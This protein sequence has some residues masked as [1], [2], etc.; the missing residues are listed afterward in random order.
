ML[1]L[2]ELRLFL[3]G[4]E[5]E[6]TNLA[7][8]LGIDRLK[9]QLEELEARTAAPEFWND[10]ENSQ[11]VLQQTGQL[12]NKLTAYQN[13]VSLYEDTLTM[14][15]LA[16]EE[17]EVDEYPALKESADQIAEK[18]EE[19]KL[20]TLLNG[21]YDAKNAILTFHAGAGGTEAQD[22]AQMLYR[23]Y[24]RWVE[25]H[26][27]K[28]KLLDMLDG[29]EAGIK[30]ASILVEGMNAYGYLKSEAG[31][32]RLVRV[33]PFDASG[34]RHTSFASLEVMPEIDD[35]L[36]VTIDEKD[37]R[38]DTYRSSGAG[39]QHVNKTES[40]IRITHI[41]TGIVV[42]C[43]NERS[44]IQNREVAMR[45]LRSK[46]VEIKEREHLEKIEDIKGVQ[47]EIAWGSQIRSYVFMPYTLVKDHRTGFETGNIG[48]VMDG[49]IDGFINAYLKAASLG[50]LKDAAE[51][52]E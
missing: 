24:T 21:E 14:V 13:L 30:S 45:M 29:E 5:Q 22:W 3:I 4:L 25:R 48:A 2:E 6:I 41:P 8:A 50:E 18:L 28:L 37:L 33:S 16:L 49:D 46:L 12:K 38:I 32:H 19:Q 11:K 42:A 47:K 15:E 31:V 44:Q 34:R 1:E 7:G 43:Q 23:M 36:E 40:A 10:P 35:D 17:K 26:G 27:F 9:R 51:A 39:G 52:E 20:S